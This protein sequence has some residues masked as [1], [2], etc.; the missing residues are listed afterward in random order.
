M[1]RFLYPRVGCHLR[2]DRGIMALSPYDL[3]GKVNL[4]EK[5]IP[6]KEWRE[7]RL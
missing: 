5:D 6:A 2:E 4:N 7:E 1:Q 3:A